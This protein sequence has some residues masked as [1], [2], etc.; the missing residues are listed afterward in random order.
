MRLAGTLYEIYDKDPYV[1]R[2][3]ELLDGLEARQTG[4]GTPLGFRPVLSAA[5]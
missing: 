2:V 1:D 4:D 5:E 3:T